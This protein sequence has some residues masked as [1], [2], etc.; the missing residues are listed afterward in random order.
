VMNAGVKAVRPRLQGGSPLCESKVMLGR[1]HH[2]FH[3][4]TRSR[5]PWEYSEPGIFR[6]Y[7][8]N[9]IGAR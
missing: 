8:G 3:I 2:D 5:E 4:G 1:V 6:M 7:Q 9:R